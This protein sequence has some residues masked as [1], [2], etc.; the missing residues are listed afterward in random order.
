[1]LVTTISYW[2]DPVADQVPEA[3]K[4]KALLL[5]NYKRLYFC[6]KYIIMVHFRLVSS[7]A[8]GFEIGP[9]LIDP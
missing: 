7:H 3:Q 5:K 2:L 4:T 9:K 6:L 1:M 8:I